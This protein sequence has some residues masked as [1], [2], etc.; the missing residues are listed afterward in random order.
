METIQMTPLFFIYFFALFV[1][2]IFVF[3]NS[4]NSFS[5]GPPFN[6]FWSEKYLNFGKKLLIRKSHHTFLERR[7]TNRCFVLS[8]EGGQKSYQFID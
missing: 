6:P 7:T 4:Q 5:F 3:E 8:L 2:F 1:T